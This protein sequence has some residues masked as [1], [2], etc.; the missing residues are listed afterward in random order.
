MF[1]RAPF[2]PAAALGLV[3][4]AGGV[5]SAASVAT[6]QETV[7]IGVVQREDSGSPAGM[8]SKK[9]MDKYGSLL[10]LDGDQKQALQ[11]LHDGYAAQYQASS[12]ENREAM[13]EVTRSF[14]D[15]Q[16]PAVFR[17]KMPAIRAK[18]LERTREL[19]RAFMGDLQA[20]LS[21]EQQARWPKVERQRRRETT[22][23]GGLSGES[24]N[25]L[26]VVDGL[27]VVPDAPMSQVLEEYELDL[28]RALSAKERLMADQPDAAG[29]GEFNVEEFRERMEKM[30]EAGLK[31]RDVNER[32]SRRIEA[33]V[34]ADNR[35]EFKAAVKR[36]TFPRV[37]RPSRATRMLDEALKLDD[38]DSAQREAI[39]SL[40]A[41]YQ[42]DATP[43]NDRWAGAIE[44]DEKS[45]DRGGVMALPGGGMMQMRFGAEDDDSPVAQARK[46]RR[47]LDDRTREKLEAQLRPE[48]KARLPKAEDRE[49]GVWAGHGA[50]MGQQIIVEERD[51]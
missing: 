27:K 45:G 4:A 23:R 48:Q 36:D 15:S 21:S 44:E 9:S 18:Y 1:V 26:D 49:E 5:L 8:I 20:L 41:A 35:P 29:G 24:V 28:D 3:M 37:Y 47:E 39:T 17:E 33:L 10:G 14:E 19:E 31:V 34:A 30:R 2:G 11:T 22:L 7:R 43:I 13:A 16:D 51:R 32:H 42:R 12:K 40:R 25:L 38:L 46:Q 6:G 50:V